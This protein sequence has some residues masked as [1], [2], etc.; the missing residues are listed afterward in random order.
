MVKYSVLG[1]C[2]ECKIAADFFE[3]LTG[4]NAY[5]VIARQINNATISVCK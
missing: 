4:S 3:V 2:N 5:V 1:A